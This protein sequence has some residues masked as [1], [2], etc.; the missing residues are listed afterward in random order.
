MP[1]F[2]PQRPELVRGVTVRCIHDTTKCRSCQ[3][4][5]SS[6]GYYK[7]VGV[8]GTVMNGEAPSHRSRRVGEDWVNHIRVAFIGHD[9][10]TI[11]PV[12]EVELVAD[13]SPGDMIWK[14][15]DD[16][17]KVSAEERRLNHEYDNASDGSSQKNRVLAQMDYTSHRRSLV[18]SAFAVLIP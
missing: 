11:I 8:L 15:Q 10:P 9:R 6:C 18:E 13:M 5:L 14:W 7:T 1:A 16:M 3:H 12:S 2:V 4:S 17:D